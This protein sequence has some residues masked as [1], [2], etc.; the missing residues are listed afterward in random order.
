MAL[1]VTAL[2]FTSCGSSEGENEVATAPTV[3]G[4]SPIFNGQTGSGATNL[5]A[6]NNVKGQQQCPQGQRMQD[7]T[8]ALQSQSYGSQI[9]GQLVAGGG[10]GGSANSFIGVNYG[11]RDLMYVTQGN[12][13]YTVVL[14]LCTV[15]ASNNYN[16]NQYQQYP[17][18][19]QSTEYIGASAGMS[20]F[21]ADYINLSM[22]YN[23]TSGQA[24]GR[25][26][27]YSQGYQGNITTEFAPVSTNQ[28]PY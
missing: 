13:G 20:N 7:L 26:T 1:S 5:S 17:N 3:Q 11:T 21:R 10:A 2:L 18:T 12:A 28:Y 8:F 19:Q 9:Y 24:S 15:P 25:I 22:G 14:S 16:Y 6:W 27:F 23:S 4:T